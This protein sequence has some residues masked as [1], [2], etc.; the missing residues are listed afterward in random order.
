M[1]AE[2]DP[3]L[4]QPEVGTVGGDEEPAFSSDGQAQQGVVL[5]FSPLLD[6]PALLIAEIAHQFSGFPPILGARLPHFGRKSIERLYGPPRLLRS[7]AAPQLGEHN[8]SVA[9]D[10]CS[11]DSLHGVCV[12]A[13]LPEVDVDVRVED[14]QRTTAPC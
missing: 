14:G 13:A 4:D 5:K 2:A 12:K 11:I 8:S 3:S 9:H 6:V 1:D 7:G 10:E